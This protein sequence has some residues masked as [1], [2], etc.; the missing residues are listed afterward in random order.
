MP[1]LVNGEDFT[2]AT[3]DVLFRAGETRACAQF[4]IINDE[5][6]EQFEESFSVCID[7]A[8]PPDDVDITSG[9]FTTTTVIIQDDDSEWD[10]AILEYVG[11]WVYD[12]I[13]SEVVN[14]PAAGTHPL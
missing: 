14:V 9:N 3:R 12:H 6:E 5:V 4:D 2:A 13:I 7:S 8:M 11:V 10:P 1:L